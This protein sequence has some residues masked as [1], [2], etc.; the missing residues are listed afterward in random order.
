M[1]PTPSFGWAWLTAIIEAVL[2]RSC[3]TGA[4]LL[5]LYL[6]AL[7]AIIARYNRSQLIACTRLLN[8]LTRR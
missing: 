3:E 2:T 8:L 7:K 5:T 6:R 1:W 4:I